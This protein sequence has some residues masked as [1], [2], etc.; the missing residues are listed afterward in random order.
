MA[1]PIQDPT[2][3]PGANFTPVDA[4]DLD[5]WRDFWLELTFDYE[6]ILADFCLAA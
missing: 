1:V 2:E 5:N 4:G 6:A 3:A